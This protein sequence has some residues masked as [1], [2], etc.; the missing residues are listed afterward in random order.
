MTMEIV[1]Y[2]INGIRAAI[3]KGLPDWVKETGFDVYCFQ[4]IKAM[5][6][7]FDDSVFTELGYHAYWYPA[8]KKGYSGVGVLSRKEPTNVV[9]G[10]GIEAYDYEGRTLQ[11]EFDELHLINTYFPSGS[12]GDER[13]AFKMQFLDDYY[14]WIHGLG[15][16]RIVHVGDFNICNK[17]IDIHDPVRN[18]DTSG[19]KP[20]EREWMD[21]YFESGFV[22][23]FRE[24]HA[25][26]PD[27]YSWWSY[28][29]G[30]R[31]NNKGWRIDYV[32]AST[33][34]REYLT[35]ADILDQVVHSDHC[36]VYAKFE[37]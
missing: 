31:R 35:D 4:E 19:F 20:E 12:S 18:A 23:S 11:L 25:D 16:D 22:D 32:S 21:K 9:Y 6:E 7:Q 27:R 17:P 34:L 29:A 15:K 30:A 28:R 24:F 8:Q 36:P 5:P 10:S 26:E 33:P 14:D 1:S 13:Q 2:N 37:F 3:N